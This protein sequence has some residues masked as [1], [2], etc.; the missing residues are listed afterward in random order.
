MSLFL[1]MLPIYLLGN[2]HCIGMCGPL[3]MMLGQHKY[4]YFYFWGR[5]LSFT[6]AGMLSGATGAVLT[7]VLQQFHVPAMTSFLF[8]GII[9]LIGFYSLAGL[10]YPGHQWLSKR[11]VKA[12]QTLSMLMLRDQAWPTFLFGFFT[13]ALPCGQTLIVFSACALSGD[14]A[15][16]LWNGFAFAIL[17]SPSLLLAMHMHALFR[18]IK[19]YYNKIIGGCALLVGIL[20]VCRGFAEIDLID[21]W[22]LNPNSPSH[23]HVVVY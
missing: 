3:V 13:L 9:I 4:R 6:L 10:S 7:A 21:H 22:V 16:G 18:Q 20:A 19:P 1:A 12:N 14:P 11:L 23:Y 17:T 15:V 5:T 2:L 8:G